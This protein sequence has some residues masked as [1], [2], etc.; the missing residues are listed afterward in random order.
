LLQ[1][2]VACLGE[3]NLQ[4]L[5]D[6]LIFVQRALDQTPSISNT[7]LTIEGVQLPITLVKTDEFSSVYEAIDAVKR[8][9]PARILR[10]CKEQLYELVKSSDPEEK[11][12]VVDIDDIENK[13]DVEFV[14]GVGVTASMKNSPSKVGYQG[15]TAV[16]LF[17]DLV[18]QDQGLDA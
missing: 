12:S 14:V 3:D 7:L 13:A 17:K 4:K 5:R 9:V 16:D 1:S 15:L 6:N 11:L 8:K 10:L 2:I 18:E